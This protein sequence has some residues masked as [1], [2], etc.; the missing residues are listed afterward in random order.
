[1]REK[2]FE[3]MLCAGH[4]DAENSYTFVRE[5]CAIDAGAGDGVW[6][7]VEVGW[8]RRGADGASGTGK[9]A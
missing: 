2:S 5:D 3:K 7:G 9:A 8:F 4:M 1:V 6:D